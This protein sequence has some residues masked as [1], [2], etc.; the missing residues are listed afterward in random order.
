MRKVWQE[1]LNWND[2]T[3]GKADNIMELFVGTMP[4]MT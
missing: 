4:A 3:V 2:A 1:F